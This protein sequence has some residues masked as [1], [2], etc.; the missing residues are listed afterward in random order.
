MF[1]LASLLADASQ[2]GTLSSDSIS[3]ITESRDGTI[4][5]GTQGGGLNRMVRAP[6]GLIARTSASTRRTAATRWARGSTSSRART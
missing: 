6:D 5:V 4:W 1:V 2:P 3:V